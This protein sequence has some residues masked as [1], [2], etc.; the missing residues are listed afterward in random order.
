MSI[1]GGKLSFEEQ[2][3]SK[4]KFLSMFSHQREA[5]VYIFLQCAVLKSGENHLDIPQ[6][7]CLRI[8]GYVAWLGLQAGWIIVWIFVCKEYLFQEVYLQHEI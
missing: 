7:Q 6:F 8:F 1:G 5:I 4:S 3:V 2:I